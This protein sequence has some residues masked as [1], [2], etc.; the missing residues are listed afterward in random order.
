[1]TE[2]ADPPAA[3]ASRGGSWRPVMALSLSS[4][5]GVWRSKL[6][7][8]ALVFSVVHVAIR[9]AIVVGVA[10]LAPGQVQAFLTP[11]F[12]RDMIF[13]QASLPA[14]IVLGAVGTRTTTRDRLMGGLEFLLS[15]SLTR[16]GYVAARS[17]GPLVAAAILILLPAILMALTIVALV[18]PLP[19]GTP[20][21]LWGSIGMAAVV[22]V[23]LG[24]LAAGLGSLVED[25]R[26]ATGLW[27]AVAWATLPLSGFLDAAGVEW[28]WAVAPI[29]V[30]DDT[31]GTLLGLPFPGDQVLLGWLAVAALVILPLGLLYHR[32]REVYG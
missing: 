6:V 2:T 4:L 31:A 28:A 15:K 11:G 30:A 10:F 24:P 21:D 5:N 20:G 26:S 18:S 8:L 12:L 7:M 14:V 22:S 23:A 25:L 9:A 27:L 1:M 13:L 17:I 32:T 19:A 3:E 29:Q 16:W